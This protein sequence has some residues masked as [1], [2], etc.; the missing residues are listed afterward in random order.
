MSE[1]QLREKFLRY[2]KRLEK[3]DPDL[4]KRISENVDKL[5]SW[6]MKNKRDM[7]LAELRKILKGGKADAGKACF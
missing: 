1:E 5:V 4:A 6:Y 7:T 3:T 2:A